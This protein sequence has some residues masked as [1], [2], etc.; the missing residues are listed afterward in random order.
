MNASFALLSLLAT[1]V[2]AKVQVEHHW[3]VRYE[4]D[5]SND[6]EGNTVW[7]IDDALCDKA[8][9]LLQALEGHQTVTCQYDYN[10]YMRMS[11]NNSKLCLETHHYEATTTCL[12][13][14]LECDSL[15][16]VFRGHYMG[17]AALAGEHGIEDEPR[18]ITGLGAQVNTRRQ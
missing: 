1:L 14:K 15:P 11:Y 5:G 7:N 8:I 4:K 13:A 18:F 16:G 6:T 9:D 12:N 17:D 3:F 10:C 2:A